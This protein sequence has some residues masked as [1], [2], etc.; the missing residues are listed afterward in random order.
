[1]YVTLGDGRR[2]HRQAR[3][4]GLPFRV[5]YVGW[6]LMDGVGSMLTNPLA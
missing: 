4:E 6:F 2:H 1:M 5:N 3:G